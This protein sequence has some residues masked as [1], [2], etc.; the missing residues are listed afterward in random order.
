MNNS[1]KKALCI[2]AVCVLLTSNI[3]FADTEIK[4]DNSTEKFYNI[5]TP[6][7]VFSKK[8]DALTKKNDFNT[9]KTIAEKHQNDNNIQKLYHENFGYFEREYENRFNALNELKIAGEYVDKENIYEQLHIYDQIARS[10]T[11]VWKYKEA[12]KEYKKIAK[13]MNDNSA[14]LEDHQ[15]INDCVSRMYYY[16]GAGELDKVFSLYTKGKTFLDNK[17]P[18]DNNLETN[19]NGPIIQYYF[20]TRDLKNVKDALDYH[21]SLASKTNNTNLKV[22]TQKEYLAYYQSISDIEKIEET[23]KTIKKLN[24]GLYKED[25]IETLQ[26]NLTFA[27]TYLGI[28]D[29][30]QYS[31]DYAIEPTKYN[32]KITAYIEKAEKHINKA[33]SWAEKYKEL[34]PTIYAMTLQTSANAAIKKR[35]Y[36]EAEVLMKEAVKYYKKASPE[37]SYFLFGG[38]TYLGRVYQ[39][40]NQYEK[41]IEK[42]KEMEIALNEIEKPTFIE[43]R[44]LYHETAEAYSKAGKE[45]EAL[46]YID[47]AIELSTAKFGADSIRAIGSMNSKVDIYKN[48]GQKDVAVEK[49]KEVLFK[50]KE[51][52]INNTYNIEFECYFLIAKDNLAKG[53]LDDA[54]ANASKALET[55]FSKDTKECA[56]DLIS[57]IYKQQGKKFKSLKYKL[58]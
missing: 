54:L 1:F 30:Y 17:Y 8:K 51:I 33:V 48:L 37:P 6:D 12:E 10:Y 38:E 46:N 41:A 49:A 4:N 42:Y 18:K 39:D 21:W 29:I 2:S 43:H 34:D 40:S 16:L 22:F 31:R 3:S 45:K 47:K 50:I 32:K 24:K 11:E 44:D 52:G 53:K 23:L 7:F 13:I 58:K 55:S 27:N 19:L 9:L 28:A 26:D 15:I 36:N 20:T 56:N 35:N 5:L 14:L 57:E 25:S